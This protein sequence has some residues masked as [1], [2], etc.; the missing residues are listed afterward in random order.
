MPGTPSITTFAA[1]T[2]PWSL[3]SLDSNF[4]NVTTLLASFNNYGNYLVDTGAAN[5]YV[6]TLAAGQTA[7]LAA[8]L[9]VQFKAVNANTGASTLN[10]NATGVKNILNIDGSTLTPG[11]IPANGIINVIYDGTQYLMLGE[12]ASGWVFIQS[13]TA[14]VSAT[15]DFTTGIGATYDQYM[16]KLTGIIPATAGSDL[17]LRISTD[18][19]ATYLAAN[20]AHCRNS[21]S[22]AG[23]NTPAGNAADAKILV[24]ANLFNGTNLPLDGTINFAGPS[25]AAI[26]QNFSYSSGYIDNGA[27]NVFLVTGN[28]CHTGAA[29]LN[30]V[31]F[32]MSAGNITSGS[33]ALYGLKKS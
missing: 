7:S 8:G 5:A 20:Y 33:I 6:V 11:Q 22:S 3:A 21:L 9:P 29:A 19:G 24:A 14:A 1:S 23:T 26:F 17:W 32:L 13:K 4:V 18:G 2:P 27:A 15:L 31:R 28:G 12:R 10:V 25:N 16:F 30:A